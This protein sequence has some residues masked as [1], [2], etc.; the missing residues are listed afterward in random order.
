MN[1]NTQSIHFTAD[2]KL[3]DFLEEKLTKLSQFSD[4]IVSVDVKLKLEKTGQIQ[5]KIVEV[6]L[7]IPGTTLFAKETNKTFETSIDG[8]VDALRRQILKYK[9]RQMSR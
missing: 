4:R 9:E 2:Q 1:I 7:N 8:C 6:I 5:D 3:L